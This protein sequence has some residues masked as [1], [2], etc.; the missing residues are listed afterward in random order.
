MIRLWKDKFIV[1]STVDETKLISVMDIL[2]NEYQKYWFT[3][4][5]PS[6]VRM[7]RHK[8]VNVGQLSLWI[9]YITLKL[10]LQECDANT[11]D[12]QLSNADAAISSQWLSLRTYSIF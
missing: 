5:A 1:N 6:K 8:I 12:V 9:I 3:G 2:L 7:K 10:I 11:Q 4:K